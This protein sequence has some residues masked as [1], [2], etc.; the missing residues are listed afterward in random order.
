MTVEPSEFSLS[1]MKGKSKEYFCAQKLFKREN[2]ENQS[3]K[4]TKNSYARNIHLSKQICWMKDPQSYD[5]V[6]LF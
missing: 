3:H 4:M 1:V 2:T 6:N 5:A